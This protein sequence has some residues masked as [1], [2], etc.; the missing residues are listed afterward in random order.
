MRYGALFLSLLLTVA[1]CRITGPVSTRDAGGDGGSAADT[2]GDNISDADEGAGTNRDSDND[3][4]PDFEDV[5]SDNDGIPDAIEAGDTDVGTPPEDSDGDLTPDFIDE[6]SDDNGILDANE[7]DGDI[8]GDSR[9]NFADLDDDGDRVPDGIE[10][11]GSPNDPPD[12]DGDGLDDF[13]DNDSDNDTIS[14]GDERDRDTDNDGMP[15]AND[16]D[17]DRDGLLDRDEAGDA[18]VET[19][20][21]NSDD[22]DL[23]DFRDPDSDNDGL[24]DGDEVYVHHTSPTNGDSDGDMISDLIE[25][26]AG[27]DPNDITDNPRTRGDFVFVVPYM[28]SPDPE[29]DTLE[30][31]TAIQFADV[32]FLFDRSGSMDGEISA[33]Q[34]AV[35]MTLGDLT[36]ADTL[37]ACT[38]DADCSGGNICNPFS[39]TCTEDPSATNCVPSLWSGAGWYVDSSTLTNRLSVQA[40]PARTSSVGL[41][42]SA[43]S[44]GSDERLYDAI[45]AV[46]QPSAFSSGVSGC[47]PAAMGLIGC[48]GYRTDAVR[49]LVVFTDEDSDGGTLA[50]AANALIAQNITMIGVWSG[51]ATSSARNALVDVARDSMSLDRGGAPLVFNG[52]DA[53]VVPAV[54]MAIREIIEGVPLRVTIDATDEP[55]D[56]GDA[57]QF[58]DQL[59][60]NVVSAG[61]TAVD[62][63][64]EDGDG[65]TETFPSVTPGNPV[66]W[67]VVP[68]QNDTVMPALTPLVYRARLTV[69]GDGSPLD[70]RI[71]Y[72]LIPPEIPDPGGPD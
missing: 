72:F 9:P 10:I 35:T 71:V 5:D 20:P 34:G 14:D 68:L 19:P 31:Q 32:Y 29:E 51:G 41:A 28:Q 27:T 69:S 65:V 4:T 38:A 7:A 1:G 23:P 45:R 52:S 43:D 6:D 12:F 15:D 21:R 22:D 16:L 53:G 55:D 66:C 56:A 50:N 8:D 54:T 40:D 18:L 25:V 49:I 47:T 44:S 39:M 46:A 67:D 2:D 33:L 11:A 63:E 26:G 64:D 17:S 24:G 70:S 3:G 58:I 48:P 60:T 61:C 59:V 62:V 36:C 57:L 13:Q 37:L 42:F 30:F